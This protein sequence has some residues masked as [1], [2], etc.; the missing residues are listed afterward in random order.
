MGELVKKIIVDWFLSLLGTA[1][2][3]LCNFTLISKAVNR[4]RF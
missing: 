2:R 3:E 4:V 1:D